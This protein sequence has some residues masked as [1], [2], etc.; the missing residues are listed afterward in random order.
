MEARISPSSRS[1][2]PG[3]AHHRFFHG[4]SGEL[5]GQGQMRLVVLGHH[6]AAAGFLVQAVDDARTRHAADA[7][8]E[9]WQWCSRALTRV[10]SSWPAAG[11]TTRP[12]GLL[13]TRSDSSSKGC[14][15]G[16]PPAAPHRRGHPASGLPR[17]RRPGASGWASLLPVDP[18]VTLVNQ[19][20]QGAPGDRRVFFPQINVQ[21]S[22]GN[23]M[24]DREGFGTVSHVKVM[25][26]AGNATRPGRPAV[27]P[28]VSRRASC[29][30]CP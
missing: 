8:K 29:K 6:Q 20:L 28:P 26:A 4:A 3:R 22:A 12:G 30:D 17:L 5:P 14:P 13:S 9:P 7:A 2:C 18:D 15:A 1:T 25:R 21:A 16:C 11:C 19:P 10:C 24:L 27:W 23:G